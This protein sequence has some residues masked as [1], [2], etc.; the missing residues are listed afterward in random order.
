[1]TCEGT[2][3]GY[4]GWQSGA[5]GERYGAAGQ[6]QDSD[7][8]AKL[9][10]A[11]HTVIHELGTTGKK[12]KMVSQFFNSNIRMASDYVKEEFD[13]LD[14]DDPEIIKA[15]LQDANVCKILQ[16]YFQTGDQV[17]PQHFHTVARL[18][19]WSEGSLLHHCCEQNYSACLKL[20]AY[21]RPAA[22]ESVFSCEAARVERF[23]F[24]SPCGK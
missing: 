13:K 12:V 11:W 3:A 21:L 14:E 23:L 2:W 4:R 8:D 18:S 22:F 1:M 16:L 9:E 19:L 15:V 10:P 6:N 20:L 17:N 24:S 5:K 7:S